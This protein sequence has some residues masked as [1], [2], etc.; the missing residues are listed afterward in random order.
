MKKTF[1]GNH[2]YKM[3]KV[4]GLCIHLFISLSLIYKYMYI[5]PYTYTYIYIFTNIYLR[6]CVIIFD[7]QF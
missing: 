7:A 4:G 6:V 5:Y 3:L 2:V 1:V